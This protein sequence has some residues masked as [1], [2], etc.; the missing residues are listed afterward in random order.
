MEF[1]GT[2]GAET[3]LDSADDANDA[4]RQTAAPNLAARPSKD[5]RRPSSTLQ[6]TGHLGVLRMMENFDN[7]PSNFAPETAGLLVF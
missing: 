2:G 1:E 3:M 7:L 5:A 4:G 6:S